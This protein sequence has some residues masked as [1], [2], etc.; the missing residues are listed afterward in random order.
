M[1]QRPQP[2]MTAEVG[3]DLPNHVSEGPQSRQWKIVDKRLS[4]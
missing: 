3:W 4:S 1:F 2:L